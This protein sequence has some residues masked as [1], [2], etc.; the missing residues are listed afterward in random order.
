MKN[1]IKSKNGITLTTLVV[2]II[3]MTT[4]A[5]VTINYTIR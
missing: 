5:G 3:I 4:V 1:F 2:A